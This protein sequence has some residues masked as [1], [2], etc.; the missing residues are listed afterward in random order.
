MNIATKTFGHNDEEE[1]GE[2]VS[3]SNSSRRGKGARRNTI[4]KDGE[5]SRGG[6]IQNPSHLEFIKAKGKEHFLHVVPTYLVEG[7]IKI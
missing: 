2:R 1:Q 6:K 3:L 4:D 5:K 7:F